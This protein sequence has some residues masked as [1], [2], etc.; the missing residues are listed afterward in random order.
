MNEP[1]TVDKSN[2]ILISILAKP[3]AK[4][5]AITDITCE[6]VGVQINAP[7]TEGEANAELLKY[8]ASVLGIRKG[9]VI[10]ERVY[11]H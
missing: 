3:G 5:N 1:I 11:V 4:Q 9:D 10:F 6:G 8:I 2:N 7:P